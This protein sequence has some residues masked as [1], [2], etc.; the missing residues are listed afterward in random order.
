ENNPTLDAG[1]VALPASLGDLV[2]SDDDGDGVQ[3][4]DE[5]GVEGVTVTLTGAGADG[6]IGTADDTTDTTTTD[7]DGLWEAY[8]VS[9]HGYLVGVDPLV[10]LLLG[11]RVGV[12]NGLSE[13]F[14]IRVERD[15]VSFHQAFSRGEPLGP[16]TA[17]GGSEAHRITLSFRLDPT[18]F[19]GPFPT[20]DFGDDLFLIAA[21]QPGLAVWLDGRECT[22]PRGLVD[23]AHRALPWT[24]IRFRLDGLLDGSRFGV[25]VLLD[26][27]R[28]HEKD[29]VLDVFA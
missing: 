3:D 10:N 27:A 26:W 1:I 7:D 28:E 15:G 29:A 11:L 6:I 20:E 18:V 24:A 19:E 17:A 4:D 9:T 22:Q 14:D 5:A 23:Y 13:D 8:A 16:P 21:L 25:A 12:L 2:F